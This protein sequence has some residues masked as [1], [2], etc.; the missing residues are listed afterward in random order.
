MSIESMFL[1]ITSIIGFAWIV[2]HIFFPLV[3]AII[4][5]I[6]FTI[7]KFLHIVPS[8][9]VRHP[10]RLLMYLVKSFIDGFIT[11]TC[12]Y[13]T[14]VQSKSDEWIWKPYFNYER[15]SK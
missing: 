1:T 14:T 12:R 5:S 6:G 9:G 2:Y 13:G 3:D 4:F 10:I 15:I 11:K 8:K 7:F